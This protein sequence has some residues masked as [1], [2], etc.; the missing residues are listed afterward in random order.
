MRGLNAIEVAS[1]HGAGEEYPGP[2][3]KDGVSQWEWDQLIDFLEDQ[4]RRNGGR[5]AY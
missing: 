2:E 1:V 5:P 4:V 3:L